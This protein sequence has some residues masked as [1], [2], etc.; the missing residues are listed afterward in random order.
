LKR[1]LKSA[2]IEVRFQAAMALSYLGEA[3]G[4]DVLAHCAEHEPAFRWHSLAA[5]TSMSDVKAGMALSKLLHVASTEARYGAFCALKKRSPNDPLVRGQ[6]LAKEFSLHVIPSSATPM[7]HLSRATSPE[8]VVFGEGQ[9]LKDDLLFLQSGLTVKGI[10]DNQIE[11]TKY[12]PEGGMVRKTTSTSVAEVVRELAAAGCGYST[13]VEFFR[14]AKQKSTLDSRLAVNALP[15]L[16]RER[17]SSDWSDNSEEESTTST[18][19]SDDVPAMFGHADVEDRTLQ[20]DDVAQ[21]DGKSNHNDDSGNNKP[22][23]FGKLNQTF[24]KNKNDE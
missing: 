13:L 7:L 12:F 21:L 17:L 20:R 24:T 14:E 3:D 23:F 9:K 10:G 15:R 6:F 16:G 4:L 19:A 5:L 18:Y 11:I 2:E 8:I 1:A 22:S